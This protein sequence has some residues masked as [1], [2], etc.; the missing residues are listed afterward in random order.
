MPIHAPLR[1]TRRKRKGLSTKYRLPLSMADF[2]SPSLTNSCRWTSRSFGFGSKVSMWL[3]PP[4]IVR[5]MH[6]LALA[7]R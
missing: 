6:R 7:G 1:P 4:S 5:K 3:G 2:C